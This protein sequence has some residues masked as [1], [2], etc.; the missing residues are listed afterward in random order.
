[1]KNKKRAIALAL[2]VTLLSGTVM[3]VAANE[4]SAEPATDVSATDNQIVFT[5]PDW[6]EIPAVVPGPDEY[7]ELPLIGSGP[8]TL[9]SVPTFDFLSHEISVGM[10]TVFPAADSTAVADPA[11][12]TAHGAHFVTVR[13]MRNWAAGTNSNGWSVTATMSTPFRAVD[14]AT[15]AVLTGADAHTLDGARII[16]ARGVTASGLDMNGL[17]MG[18]AGAS[19]LPSHVMAPDTILE[20]SDNP[21]SRMVAG[22]G[23]VGQGEGRTALSFGN[24]AAVE[25]DVINSGNLAVGTFR[26]TI[27]WVLT[28]GTVTGL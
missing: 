16:F 12:T 17:T 26:A 19:P 2:A 28:P 18:E 27:D 8:F 23:A 22:T 21:V 20:N 7:E 10:D 13:D 6:N 15:G 5:E 14:P 1:M 9:T 4:P 11:L 24:G 3:T 25:L